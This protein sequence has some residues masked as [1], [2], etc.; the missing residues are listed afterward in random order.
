MFTVMFRQRKLKIRRIFEISEVNQ[1]KSGE[2]ITHTIKQWDAKLDKLQDVDSS[3]RIYD[4]INLF[5]GMTKNEIEKDLHEKEQ[6]LR[7]LVSNNINTVNTVGRVIS[8][9][10]SNKE[11]FMK[12][13]D[14]K[15]AVDKILGNLKT[16]LSS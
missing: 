15:Y 10:Y 13:M 9:Y 16:E 12:I 7:F 6:V 8:E 3:L 1:L 4:E 2:I 11:E 14:K 5:T